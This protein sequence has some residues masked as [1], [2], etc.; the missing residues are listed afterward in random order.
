MQNGE[1]L[2]TSLTVQWRNREN[3]LHC[4]E[5]TGGMDG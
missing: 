2:T 3:E 1:G 4:S 5:K